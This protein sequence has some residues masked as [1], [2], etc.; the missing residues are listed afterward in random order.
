MKPHLSRQGLRVLNLLLQEPLRL[1]SGADIYRT[2]GIASG[3]MY[4]LLHRFEIDKWISGSWEN[5]NPS[6][7]GRPKR[8]LYRLTNLGEKMS[9]QILSE[10]VG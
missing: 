2:L 4:P 1:W 5:I 8:R 6:K 9:K 3:T 10:F 7:V